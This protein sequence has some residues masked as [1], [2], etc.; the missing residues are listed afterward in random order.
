MATSRTTEQREPRSLA[1]WLR[2]AG[3]QTLATLF[4]RRADLVMPVPP[5]FTVLAAR[6]ATRPSVLAAIDRLNRFELE[7]LELLTALPEPITR[8]HIST[9]VGDVPPEGLHAAV[10]RLRELAIVWGNE[11][12]LHVL[13]TVRELVVEPCGLGPPI[14]DAVAGLSTNRLRDMLQTLSLPPASDRHTA[15]ES[16][17]EWSADKDAVCDVVA[18]AG[19]DVRDLLARLTWGPPTGTTETAARTPAVVWAMRHGLLVATGERSVVLPREIGIALRGGVI[20]RSATVAPPPLEISRLPAGTSAHTAATHAAAFV[21]LTEDLLDY[22][23]ADPPAGLRTG[24]L[25]VRDLRRTAM[26]LDRTDDVVVLIAEVAYAAGL[27]AS[28]PNDEWLPTP[29]YD[30][31]RGSADGDRWTLLAHCWMHMSRVPGLASDRDGGRGAAPLGPDL[32]RMLAAPIRGA[33]LLTIAEVPEGEA[34]SPASVAAVLESLLARRGGHFR[35]ELVN[36]TLV[37]A[38]TLGVTGA[39]AL[40]LPG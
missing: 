20:V 19:D 26:H 21:R 38:S 24:G 39:G 28:T 5:D 6:A 14:F 34:A 16:L 30:G 33:T 35:D 18:S 40:S 12:D 13:R 10:D 4:A 25:R 22:W 11:E 31:W 3:D 27:L 17:R 32:D 29:A 2:T 36:W 8:D 9:A 1:D 37:E 23:A 15:I 7:M